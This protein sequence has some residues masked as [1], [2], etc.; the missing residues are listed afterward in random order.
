[1]KLPPTGTLRLFV[2]G[3]LMRGG[4]RHPPLASQRFLGEVRTRP[5]YALFHLIDYPGLVRCE[6][7]GMIVHG[8]LY[9]VDV[10]LLPL[11]DQLEGA[12]DL[13]RLEPVAVEELDGPV[14]AYF[15]Q[16]ETRGFA[17]YVGGRWHNGEQP[18]GDSP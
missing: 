17:L 11:L 3:T 10:S 1:M 2:Y 14:Y 16:R 18:P 13:F 9:D 8:E 15:Y 12:P 6:Q 7:G 5:L 4:V